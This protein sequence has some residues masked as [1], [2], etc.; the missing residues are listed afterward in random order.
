MRRIVRRTARAPGRYGSLWRAGSWTAGRP[1]QRQRMPYQRPRS[2]CSTSL[3]CRI[4]SATDTPSL[5]L[6]EWLQTLLAKTAGFEWCH[7]SV[8]ILTGNDHKD[9]AQGALRRNKTD[10]P[11]PQRA[12]PAA[13]DPRSTESSPDNRVGARLRRT[14]LTSDAGGLLHGVAFC[15][16]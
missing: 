7:A 14:S 15:V 2:R 8:D 5:Q 12:C 6:P 1:R 13:P 16:M 9:N 3:P 11:S 10:I 4:R